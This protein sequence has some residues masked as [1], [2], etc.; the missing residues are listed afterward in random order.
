MTEAP[1][2]LVI[3]APNW[4]GDAV[5]ALPLVADIRREWP[6]THLTIA[7]RRA[8]AALFA[9]VEG[10]NDVTAL[11]GGG[12]VLALTAIGRNVAVLRAGN[13][14]AALLLPNSFISAWTA[15]RAHIPQRWGFRA[16]LAGSALDAGD[17]ASSGSHAS[18]GVLP[19]AWI[20]IGHRARSTSRSHRGSG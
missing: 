4:L 12:G 2:R 6:G 17:H 18:V 13:F 14:D 16:D 20:G 9:M 10:V 11:P 5:M 7:A 3:V 15:A 19:G 1:R 8:V